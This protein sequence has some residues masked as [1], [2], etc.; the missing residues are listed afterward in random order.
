MV[1]R[2]M[3]KLQ[4][5][6]SGRANRCPECGSTVII[7]P[8]ECSEIVCGKC[9]LVLSERLINEEPEWKAFTLEEEMERSRVGSPVSILAIDKGLSTVIDKITRDSLGHEVPYAIR[10]Q[11]LRLRKHQ[12]NTQYQSNANKNLLHALS[13]LDRITDKLHIPKNIQTEAADIYRKAL[14]KRLIPGRSISAIVAASLYAACRRF[15][16]PRSLK[17]IATI[18]LV[19]KKEIARCYRLL[20]NELMMKM[21]TADPK[22][23]I[24]KIATKLNI[25]EKTQNKATQLLNLAEKYKITA[26]KD[27][28]GLAAAALYLVQ[29]REKR[30][31]KEIANVAGITEVTLRNRCKGLKN[32]LNLKL[33]RLNDFLH[34]N[35]H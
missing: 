20:L 1:F 22:T 8:D 26:G 11:M 12:M 25:T 2:R 23:Y 7:Y 34:F 27:P 35:I 28:R 16:N 13:E 6:K 29:T 33:N 5:K 24:A 4:F 21:P 10:R 14:K 32:D 30:T 18:S 3:L 9:G 19:E 31:Q 17:E 15:N